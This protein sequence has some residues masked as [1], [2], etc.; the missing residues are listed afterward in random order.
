VIECS[1]DPITETSWKNMGTVT[2]V[3]YVGNGATPGH[4]CWYRVAAVNRAGQ[5]PW[6]DP[7]LRPVM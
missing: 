3:K 7:A 6:S 4:K 2:E 5:G 1:Q